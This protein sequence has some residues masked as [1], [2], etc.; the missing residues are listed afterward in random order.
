MAR[1]FEM[2]PHGTATGLST[3]GETR[4]SAAASGIPALPIGNYVA[5]YST[6]ATAVLAT[7]SAEL[8]GTVATGLANT[9]TTAASTE[10]TEAANQASLTT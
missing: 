1:R 10:T 5:G 2:D 4:A 7:L 8:T 3:A 9:T 6:A